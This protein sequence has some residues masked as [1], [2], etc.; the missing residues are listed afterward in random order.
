VHEVEL[1]LLLVIVRAA[2]DARRQHE[3]VHAE[4]GHPKLAADLSEDAVSHLVDRTER[5]AH[6][7]TIGRALLRQI[8]RCT[9]LALVLALLAGCGGDEPS[10][11]APFRYDSGA[12]DLKRTPTSLGTGEVKVEE[13]SFTGPG[14]TRLTGYLATPAGSSETHPAVT[15]AHGAG[16]DRQ[17]LVDEAR[18]LAE[19]GAV[20]L[21]LDM[22]YSPSRAEPL[23]SDALEAVRANSDFEVECVKEV[24]RAVDLLQSLDTVDGDR[25]GYVGWSQ[26]ARMGT[27]I[28]GIERRIEAFDLIAGGAAPISAFIDQAPLELQAEVREIFEKTD[29]LHYVGLAEPSALLFQLG[30]QDGVVPEAALRELA[31]AGS[32]PKEVRWYDTG[33]LPSEELWADS[34]TWLADELDID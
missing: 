33:H 34:R 23:P 6:A 13:I 3:D 19:Q 21:T 4:G 30:R 17:E 5:V 18:Y 7:D 8:Y 25:I 24:R 20:T 26:G 11:P 15:Y 27:L 10:V 29:P 2:D 9:G 1:V 22:I 14:D 32:E 16:G 12:L 31:R 28:S